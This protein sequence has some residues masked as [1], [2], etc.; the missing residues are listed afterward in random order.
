MPQRNS[1]SHSCNI[2]SFKQLMW[3]PITMATIETW[4]RQIAFGQPSSAHLSTP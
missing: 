2:A 1:I 3:T 4:M